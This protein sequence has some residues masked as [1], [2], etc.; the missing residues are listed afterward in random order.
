VSRSVVVQA[1]VEEVYQVWHN[2]E[3]LPQFMNNLEDVRVMEGGRSH[4]KAK[5]PLGAAAEWDAEMTLDEPGRAIGWQSLEANSSVK[6]AGR[7]TFEPAPDAVGTRVDVTLEYESPGGAV[8][9]IVTKIFANP[10]AQVDEDLQRFKE[11][12]ERGS[13][14]SGFNYG[15]GSRR[16]ERDEDDATLGGSMGPTTEG[17]LEAIDAS[18]SGIAPESVDDPGARKASGQRF[19]H[20]DKDLPPI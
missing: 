8:G 11:A 16:K 12:I 13:Q 9:E 3:N 19:G 17:D 6:T 14:M 5:G 2:F 18:N 10:D 4:W 7:V 20:G 1:P 15:E